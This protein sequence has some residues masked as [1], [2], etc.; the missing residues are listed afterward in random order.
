MFFYD[1]DV[2]GNVTNVCSLICKAVLTFVS[3]LNILR[4]ELVSGFPAVLT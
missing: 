1:K 2:N 4:A 3:G